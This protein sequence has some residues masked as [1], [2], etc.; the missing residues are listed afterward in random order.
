MVCKLLKKLKFWLRGVD[1][2]SKPALILRKLLTFQPAKV[3]KTAT[4]ANLS[5]S[6]HSVCLKRMNPD[7]SSIPESNNRTRN[8][9]RLNSKNHAEVTLPI[10][11]LGER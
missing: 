4:R 6:F 8:P 1:L 10:P 7:L 2:N 11:Q 3:P 5:F 9:Q